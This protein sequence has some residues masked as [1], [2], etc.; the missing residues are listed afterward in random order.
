MSSSP[1]PR[2][3]SSTP[4]RAPTLGAGGD[5]ELLVRGPQLMR[6]YRG[7]PEATAAT[8]DADGWLHTGD[9]AAVDANGVV[10]ITDRL[11][12]LIKVK[13][14]QVAPAELEGLLCT[15][16]SVADAAVVGVPD[17]AAGERPKAFVV[18]RGAAMPDEVM[19]W[20]AER[21]AP[22]KRL[23]AVELVD[24]IPKLPSGKILRRVLRDR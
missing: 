24:E 11:K 12:E 21:V 15:H 1:A 18:A 7:R 3:G 20:M 8:I 23:C 6:G 14:F 9:L 16:P 13:G 19:T 2:R 5:G 17:E 4:T 22:H 10:R